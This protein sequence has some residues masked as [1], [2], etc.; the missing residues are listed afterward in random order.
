[1]LDKA[2]DKYIELKSKSPNGEKDKKNKG[3]KRITW[4][5]I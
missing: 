3:K 1:M 5:L 2:Y 4:F